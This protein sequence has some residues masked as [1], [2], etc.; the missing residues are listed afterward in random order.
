MPAGCSTPLLI[1]RLILGVVFQGFRDTVILIKPVS[2][3][4]E[5]TAFTTE[6]APG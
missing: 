4:D 3:V 6:R 5:T 1:T 2:Q